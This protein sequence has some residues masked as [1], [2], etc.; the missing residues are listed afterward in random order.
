MQKHEYNMKMI[1]VKEKELIVKQA[2]AQGKLESQRNKTEGGTKVVAMSRE[3]WLR[4]IEKEEAEVEVE[5]AGE[6]EQ[7]NTE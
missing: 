1:E 7:E 2:I 4:M 6:A 5:S 3:E